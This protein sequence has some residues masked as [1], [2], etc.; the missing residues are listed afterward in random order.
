MAQGDVP[1]DGEADIMEASIKLR[2]YQPSDC[3]A[4]ARLFYDTV[5]TVNARDYTPEQLDAWATGQVDL[6]EWNRTLSLH[7][8]LIA[9]EGGQIL[10]FADMD[11]TGYLDRIYVHRDH[12]GRGIA[13]S[14]CDGLEGASKAGTFTT[15]ASITAKPFFLRRGYRVVKEQQVVRYGVAMTNFVMEKQRR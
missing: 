1:P 13:T 7:H 10:G 15:H 14:L 2:P 12:Q 11:E 8:T 3:P 9:E 4:L 6:A 5:H